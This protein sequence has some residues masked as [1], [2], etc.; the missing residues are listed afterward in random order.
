MMARGKI[1]LLVAAVLLLSGV[2]KHVQAAKRVNALRQFA[3][4]LSV[5]PKRTP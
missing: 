5:T 4:A 2:P 3:L 1:F